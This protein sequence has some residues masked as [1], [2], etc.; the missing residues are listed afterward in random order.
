MLLS[1][2]H[3]NVGDGFPFV[4]GHPVTL[5]VR[6]GFFGCAALNL[7]DAA[8]GANFARFGRRSDGG[9]LRFLVKIVHSFISFCTLT[10]VKESQK[11]LC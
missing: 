3:E 11:K 9:F 4:R 6:D 2:L 1:V 10:V 8:F 7:P 5:G